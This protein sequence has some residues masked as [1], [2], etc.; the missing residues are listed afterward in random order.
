MARISVS[1]HEKQREMDTEE[2]G[3]T[4]RPF[5]I[6]QLI[7]SFQ[8]NF[9]PLA[10]EKLIHFNKS[11]NERGRE[12]EIDRLGFSKQR[13]KEMPFWGGKASSSSSTQSLGN[14]YQNQR[15]GQLLDGSGADSAARRAGGTSVSSIARSFLPHRRRLRLDPPSKLFFPCMYHESSSAAMISQ[16]QP[17][18]A[19][20][21]FVQFDL[22]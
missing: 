1:R 7:I 16:W 4:E 14:S 21:D 3:S 9:S 20:F 10:P 6:A 12:R 8:P 13:Q 22:I 15:R 5:L 19:A 18:L 11:D 17:A 2:H